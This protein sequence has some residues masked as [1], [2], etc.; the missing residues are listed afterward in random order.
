MVRKEFLYIIL[1]S[2]GFKE[3]INFSFLPPILRTF[4]ALYLFVVYYDAVYSSDYTV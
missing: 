1:M 2:F 3:L 4:S